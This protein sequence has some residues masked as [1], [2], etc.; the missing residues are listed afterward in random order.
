MAG[1]MKHNPALAGKKPTMNKSQAK[2]LKRLLGFIW[3]GYKFRFML[4]FLCIVI[5]SIVSAASGSFIGT[6]FDE[7]IS[8][9]LKTS[10]PDYSALLGAI[11]RMGAIFLCGIGATLLQQLLMIFITQG[12]I[13]RKSFIIF[14][15]C[16][17]KTSIT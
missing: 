8:E 9:L 15:T 14:H 1:P 13:L 11:M 16:A 5:T 12:I 3:K 4:V 10:A 6:V 2:T 17:F 7:Y